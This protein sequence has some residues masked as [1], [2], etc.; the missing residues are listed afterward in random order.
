M[1]EDNG[2][3]PSALKLTL[4]IFEHTNTTAT[5]GWWAHG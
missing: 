3:C 1:P 5:W 4:L 2:T